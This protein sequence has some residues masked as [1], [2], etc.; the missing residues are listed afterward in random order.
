MRA[1]AS[2]CARRS[3]C[4][5]P[6]AFA[7]P[8]C[9]PEGARRWR[10]P[11]TGFGGVPFGLFREG[12]L[13]V[14]LGRGPF[15]SLYAGVPFSPRCWRG[16]FTPAGHASGACERCRPCEPCDP[17]ASPASRAL[18]VPQYIPLSPQVF[19]SRTSTNDSPQRSECD[20][21]PALTTTT[22]LE[23]DSQAPTRKL[24]RHATCPHELAARARARCMPL[25]ACSATIRVCT[26]AMILLTSPPRQHAPTQ[27]RT[28]RPRISGRSIAAALPAP[29]APRR[30]WQLLR[31]REPDQRRRR[32]APRPRQRPAPWCRRRR[33]PVGG[34]AQAEEEGG[35]GR[36]GRRTCGMAW[37]DVISWP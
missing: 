25:Q 34:R 15:W 5:G 9:N 20:G 24:V 33:R 3:A 1:G 35:S 4:A 16:P 30:P 32:P 17:S 18:Q 21:P 29:T 22:A 7:A 13:L 6:I 31:H 10:G 8:V 23:L 36:V 28:V 37:A 19:A 2:E 26:A 11:L 14:H 27:K 12:S